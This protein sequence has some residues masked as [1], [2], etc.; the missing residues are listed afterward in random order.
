SISVTSM[1]SPKASESMVLSSSPPKPAPR[2]RTRFSIDGGVD[3]RFEAGTP[4][5]SK[6]RELL[7]AKHAK[8]AKGHERSRSS[9]SPPAE[10]GEGRGEEGPSYHSGRFSLSLGERD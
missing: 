2:T 6:S 8:H 1:P 10:G 7:P 9:P 5:Q 3:N 4:E